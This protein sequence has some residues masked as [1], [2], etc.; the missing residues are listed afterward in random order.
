MDKLDR[1]YE[2][3]TILNSHRRPVPMETL[4]QKL[5]CS[6]KTARRAI[7]TLQ[8]LTGAPIEY[9]REQNGWHYAGE[10]QGRYELPGLWLTATE[11]YAL[12]V[13]YNLLSALQPDVLSDHISPI[14]ERI[15]GIL[16]HKHAGSP[17]IAQRIRILQQA[18]RPADSEQF[19]KIAGATLEQRQIKVLY[20]SRGQDELTE[21]VLS[22]QRIIY[23]RSNWYLDAWCHLRQQLRTFSLDCLQPYATLDEAAVTIAEE[24]LEAHYTPAYGIFAGAV[25]HKAILQ[26]SNNA[27]RWVADEQWHPQQQGKLLSDGG[28]QLEIPYNDATELIMDIL[29][30]GDDVQVIAPESLKQQVVSKLKAALEK[31]SECI[32]TV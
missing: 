21:R 31:Y 16:Q 23:Y 30:Y 24:E 14:K 7:E 5:E 11:L 13:S 22:P 6:D 4:C 17:D 29:K 9:H 18:A 15:E 32:D 10:Q 2:L 19:R 1:I 20:R 25:K 26:F 27:A 28:Y 3:N 8:T 12:L